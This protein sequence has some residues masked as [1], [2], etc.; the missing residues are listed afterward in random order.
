M[1]K[2]K[3]LNKRIKYDTYD[4]QALMEE[5]IYKLGKLQYRL[6]SDKTEI[7]Q[8]L[9][10]VRVITKQCRNLKNRIKNIL[11]VPED[12]TQTYS[13]YTKLIF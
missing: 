9:K 1:E 10:E 8:Q 3:E 13:E 7:E 11:N 12:T 2:E 5:V 4:E 6:T